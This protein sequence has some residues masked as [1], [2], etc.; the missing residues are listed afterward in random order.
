MGL[1]ANLASTLLQQ[2][3]NSTLQG[4]GALAPLQV[5]QPIQVVTQSTNSVVTQRPP[6]NQVKFSFLYSILYKYIIF[7]VVYMLHAHAY[8]VYI[9]TIYNV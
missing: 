6:Q 5:T 8:V 1:P 2:H 7:Y 3:V 9:C 4:Q